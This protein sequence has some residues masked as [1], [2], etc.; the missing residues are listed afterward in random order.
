MTIY[1]IGSEDGRKK[2]WRQDKAPGEDI[3]NFL[4]ELYKKRFSKNEDP[5]KITWGYATSG[6]FNM[7]ESLG[8]LTETQNIAPESK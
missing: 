4:S 1:T 7:K 2:R 6:N 8:L 3:E 5:E